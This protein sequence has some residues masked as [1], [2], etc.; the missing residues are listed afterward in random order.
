M[1]FK[2]IAV[3]NFGRYAG[4]I[5]FDTTVTPEKNMIL[6]KANNDR[7]KTTLFK[8]INF[9]L[10]GEDGLNK[11]SRNKGVSEWINMQKASEGDGKMYVEIKFEHNE[12][13]YRL[14]R[15]IKFEKTEKG[16]E[17]KVVGNPTAELFKNDEPQI[18][19]G[20]ITIQSLINT[21]LPKD[22]SQFFFF[23]GEE[24]QRFISNERPTV[25]EAVE[26]VLGIKELLNAK[27]DLKLLSEDLSKECGK[28][29]RKKT[30]DDKIR[31][32]LEESEK[33]IDHWKQLIEVNQ[34]ALKGAEADKKKT[35]TNLKKYDAIKKIVTEREVVEDKKK[36][37]KKTI[38]E[39]LKNLA[40]ARGNLGL[41]LL[42]PLLK[43]IVKTEEDPPSIDRWQSETAKYMLHHHTDTCV[44][45]RIIDSQAKK[46][47]ESKVL[48]LKPSK[49]SELKKVANTMLID[50]IPNT[51]Q[52]ELI[53]LLE[54]VSEERQNLDKNENELKELSKLIEQHEDV[55]GNI[56]KLQ[57][58]YDAAV[59]RIHNYEKKID[60]AKNQ[61]NGYES[62]KNWLEGEIRSS[63]VDDELQ[64]A[65]KRRD[66]CDKII[67]CIQD[68]IEQFYQKRKPRLEDVVSNTFSRLTNNPDLYRGLKIEDDFSMQVVRNDG[69]ELPTYKYS[70]SAGAS[71]IVAISMIAG[72]NK[73]A[74]RVAP[75]VIDT[76]MGRL[77]DIHRKNLIQHYSN[78]SEQ[79]IILYQ[80]SELEDDD[81][82][83]I[84]EHLA[85]EWEIVST[86]GQPDISQ[87][88]KT[89]TYYE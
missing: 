85:S 70:P 16:R 26:K 2:Y 61:K 29:M 45:D 24:I 27:D 56:K 69:T 7:G 64:K 38:A 74:T 55:E 31:K 86:P 32:D 51:K 62:K 77:D 47:L 76:P 57:N 4:D 8:A 36:D 83:I 81:I 33:L 41:V 63:V 73:F 40:A 6:V 12:E 46:V 25:E 1:R 11:Y 34:N 67:K 9:A 28:V 50:H 22:A 42:D 49:R 13:E 18:G 59:N 5:F 65:E 75:V 82:Q 89:R 17:I 44:C 79:I 39:E 87:I 19:G 54:K 14:K 66:T 30:K 58:E 88:R 84:Q 68:A 21:I 60:D 35:Q 23:D 37:L 3:H 43:I 78:M 72:L 52:K 10:Y 53:D 80:P 15:S 20:R 71:Q 48:N